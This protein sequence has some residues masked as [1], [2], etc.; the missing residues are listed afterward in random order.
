MVRNS[1]KSGAA[2]NFLIKIIPMRW[3]V[4]HHKMQKWGLL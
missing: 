1:D 4:C 2:S 3:H